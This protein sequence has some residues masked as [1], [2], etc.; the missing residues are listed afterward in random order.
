MVPR[1][2]RVVTQPLRSSPTETPLP[3][4]MARAVQAHP[5]PVYPIAG[6]RQC[7]SLFLRAP[8]FYMVPSLLS[9]SEL[10]LPYAVDHSFRL[11]FLH[12]SCHPRVLSLLRRC[13][14]FVRGCSPSFPPPLPSSSFLFF[15][16]VPHGRPP[17][18]SSSFPPPHALRHPL[19]PRDCLFP[20]GN[21]ADTATVAANT[22]AATPPFLHGVARRVPA[23]FLSL[24]LIRYIV[25]GGS[26][27]GAAVPGAPG[28]IRDK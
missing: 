8:R 24:W 27:G 28:D 3:R 7:K 18:S 17:S 14:P 10:F 4:Y 9:R 13:H 16:I 23:L 22:I 20:L 19:P 25:H 15:A 5:A 21:T 6:A 12:P 2:I 1:M 26:H 11:S